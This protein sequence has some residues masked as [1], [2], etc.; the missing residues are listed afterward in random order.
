MIALYSFPELSAVVPYFYRCS[1]SIR[2]GIAVV[3]VCYSA[4]SD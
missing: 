3:S 4:F 2:V 1:V